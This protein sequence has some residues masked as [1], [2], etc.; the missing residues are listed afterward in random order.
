VKFFLSDVFATS[1][2][3]LE[4]LDDLERLEKVQSHRHS[5]L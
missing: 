2:R 5:Q 4:S 3:L 1:S